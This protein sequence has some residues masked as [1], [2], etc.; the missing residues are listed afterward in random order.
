MLSS[1]S[2]LLHNSVLSFPTPAT[3]QALVGGCP[4]EVDAAWGFT[5]PATPAGLNA[6]MRCE[7]NPVSVTG[8]KWAEP[9]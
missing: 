6:T 7:E 4:A 5:W 8:E 9:V 1:Y 3:V 2:V